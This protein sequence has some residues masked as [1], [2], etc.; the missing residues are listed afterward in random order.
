MALL[1]QRMLNWPFLLSV[2]IAAV[3][4]MGYIL[5]GGLT[6]S[7][8][9]EVLQFFLIVFGFL[10]LAYLGLKTI[11]GF[12]GL[13]QKLPSPSYTHTWANVWHA[14]QNPMGVNGFGMIFGL[15]FV[16]AFGYWCTDFLVVQ[17][18]WPPRTCLPR[19][20]LP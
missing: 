7:I 11:G 8:Y 20:A 18:R 16:L 19:N 9:N 6:S 5:L 15:G 13:M 2:L 12:H 17:R 4:V 14:D 1:F 3:V 10:P